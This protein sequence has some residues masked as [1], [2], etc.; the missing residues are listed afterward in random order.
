MQNEP[1]TGNQKTLIQVRALPLSRYITLGGSQKLTELCFPIY[2]IGII[3]LTSQ[4]CC[5]AAVRYCIWKYFISNKNILY[6]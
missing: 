4:A 5:E 2:K 6:M 1:R 3:I